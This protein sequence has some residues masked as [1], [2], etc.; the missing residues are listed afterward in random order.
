MAPRKTYKRNKTNKR[1]GTKK[2]QTLRK[3]GY[4]PRNAYRSTAAFWAQRLEDISK[5]AER[6]GLGRPSANANSQRVIIVPAQA[7]N[8]NKI[9]PKSKGNN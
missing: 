7:K 8:Y 2:N 9:K 6:F 5:T 3:L 4:L 1:G